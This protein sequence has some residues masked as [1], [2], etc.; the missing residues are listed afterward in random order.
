MSKLGDAFSAARKAGKKESTFNGKR[1][2]TRTREEDKPVLKTASAA[3]P[4]AKK[5][6]EADRKLGAATRDTTKRSIRNYR[7]P[8]ATT[9]AMHDKK[10]KKGMACGGSYKKGK[11]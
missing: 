10:K 3:K 4:A 11:K 7:L 1:Y 5:V 9:S 8:E 2:S 6:Y